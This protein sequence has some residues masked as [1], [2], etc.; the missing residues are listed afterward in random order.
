MAGDKA[1][2][3]HQPELSPSILPSMFSEIL[4]LTYQPNDTSSTPTGC[5]TTSWLTVTASMLSLTGVAQCMVIT[6]TMPLGCCSAGVGLRNCRQS[7]YAT[8][9]ISTGPLK[10]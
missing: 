10:V 7:T 4:H 9:S 5:I 8:N 1:W 6:F 3:L 2:S